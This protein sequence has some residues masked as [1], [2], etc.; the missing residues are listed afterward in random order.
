MTDH[1]T[2]PPEG[3]TQEHAELSCEESLALVY[4]YLDGELD[5]V[6]HEEVAQHFAMCK[7]CYPHLKLEE[8]FRELLHRSAEEDACPEHVRKQVLE[9]L[10]P[11]ELPIC[12]YWSSS[13]LANDYNWMS[14]LLSCR[15]LPNSNT[16]HLQRHARKVFQIG[17]CL[18]S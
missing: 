13:D 7:R 2:R 12:G 5:G 3:D 11:Q 16:S 6:S 4:E 15:P 14:S 17:L 8:R 1:G 9:A 10:A 18:E